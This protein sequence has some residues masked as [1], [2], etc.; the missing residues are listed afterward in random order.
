MNE[1]L[2][3]FIP[4]IITFIVG[5]IV[6]PFLSHFL[7]THKM[8]KKKSV[9]KTIDGHDALLSQKIHN[10]DIR[11]VPR[12]GGIIVWLSVLIVIFSFSLLGYIFPNTFEPLSYFSRS[13]TWIPISVFV[14]TAC[15]GL[16]DDYLVCKESGTYT[17]GGLSLTKRLFFVFIVALFVAVWL[18]YKLD[19]VEI[20][21][22][23]SHVLYLGIWIIPIIILC[24]IALYGGGIIDGIDGLSG[25]V[26]A[27]MFSAYAVIA[28][29]HGHGDIAAL[30][31]SIVGGIL[32]FLWFNIPPARFFLSETGSMPLTITL[33]VIAF[34]IRE[35]LPLL[36][37]GL[38]L[39]VTALSSIIQILS[40]KYRH[41]KKVFLVAPLHNHFQ[42]IGWP[43]SKVV[44]RYWILSLCCSII[45]VILAI[46]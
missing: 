25:G 26:F 19:I 21:T 37:I 15:V 1:A 3:I 43:A 31:M 14:V 29:I 35:P 13:G 10:D 41:G 2:K 33:G 7:Y 30:C 27:S 39:F 23:S 28:Y 11:L 40:K 45:G 32:A 44:M 36:V 4:S 22:F 34:L 6:T 24:I 5:I 17:G 16:L 42:A 20:Y 38:P 12:M 8:W 46:A 9:Q 18:Y